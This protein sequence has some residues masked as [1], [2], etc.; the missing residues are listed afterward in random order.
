MKMMMEVVKV[1]KSS[2][3]NIYDNFRGSSVS[4]V[5]LIYGGDLCFGFSVNS[6]DYSMGEIYGIVLN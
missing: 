1:F 5:F 3:V 6:N 4:V 2:Q